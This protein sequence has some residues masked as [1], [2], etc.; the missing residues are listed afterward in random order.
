MGS[1]RCN[2]AKSRCCFGK[3]YPMPIVNLKLSRLRALE[4]FMSIGYVNELGESVVTDREIQWMIIV[5][6]VFIISGVLLAL[7][8]YVASITKNK[9]G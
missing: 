7:M 1:A 9:I 8:D 2:P 6:I 5:H 3:D 4:A